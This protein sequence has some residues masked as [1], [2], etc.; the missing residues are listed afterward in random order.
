MLR[1]FKIVTK[2]NN[3]CLSKFYKNFINAV[4]VPV[5]IVFKI[6]VSAAL[7]QEIGNLEM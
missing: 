6:N 7:P 1:W 2:R 3:I 5:K 4:A